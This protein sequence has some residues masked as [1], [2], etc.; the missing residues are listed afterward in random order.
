MPIARWKRIV[1]SAIETQNQLRIKQDLYK[2]E[3]GTKILKT[4]TRT[5]LNKILNQ[6]YTRQPEPEIKLMTKYETKTLII[7]RYG[8]L[9]CGTNFKGTHSSTCTSCNQIDNEHH[10]MN[11]CPKWSSP[12]ANNEMIDF[13]LIHSDSIDSI[14]SV[15]NRIA[16]IWNTKCAH[17]TMR[18]D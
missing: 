3:N 8:M 5:I 4:K 1:S 18:K 13:D 10:R 15:M 6:N 2:T 17:G 14:R 12:S 9:M 7:A 11:E 16:D